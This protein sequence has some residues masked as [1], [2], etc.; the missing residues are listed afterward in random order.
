M[1]AVKVRSLVI[2]VNVAVVPSF[3]VIRYRKYA[4]SRWLQ[5]MVTMVATDVPR[6]VTR[7]ARQFWRTW[8]VDNSRNMFQ[9]SLKLGWNTLSV[10]TS[11]KF[12]NGVSQLI[13][14][15][16]NEPKFDCD[17]FGIPGVIFKVRALTFDTVG[18]LSMLLGVSDAF[19]WLS[20]ISI[21]TFL[22]WEAYLHNNWSFVP[23][24]L[25]IFR[26]LMRWTPWSFWEAVVIG[27]HDGD[28]EW[29]A[30]CRGEGEWVISFNGLLGTADIGVYVVHTNCVYIYYICIHYNHY[31][32][33]QRQHTI[34]R[35]Q[36]TL[37][38]R[39]LKK[40]NTK[41]V[42]APIKLT[43]HWRWQLYIS[44]QFL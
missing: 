7:V 30:E 1:L 41:N 3:R 40:E 43:C 44:L 39:S 16:H 19:C 29:G 34:Y 22:F 38:K 12:D 31:F 2:T 15:M 8:P 23:I 6:G 24:F 20:Y 17:L 33:S 10:E 26:A 18:L 11:H 5:Q 42:R 37:R 4:P 21:L 28:L 35:S 36:S 27:P 25:K 32:P 13:K 9:I 14:Y